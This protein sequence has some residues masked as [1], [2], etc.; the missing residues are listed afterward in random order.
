MYVHT[1]IISLST[2]MYIRHRF[3]YRFW[4][5]PVIGSPQIDNRLT[6][7]K[8]GWWFGR[9]IEPIFKQLPNWNGVLKIKPIYIKALAPINTQPKIQTYVIWLIPVAFLTGRVKEAKRTFHPFLVSFFLCP[10]TSI[11]VN[12]LVV[13][14]PRNRLQKGLSLGIGLKL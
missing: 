6:S 14:Y 2:Y 9:T 3:T 10:P 8:D 5:M 4:N 1:Y 12:W 13:Y 7:S 11:G